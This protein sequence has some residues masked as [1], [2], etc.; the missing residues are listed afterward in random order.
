MTTT[1]SVAEMV[2]ALIRDVQTIESIYAATYSDPKYSPLA[3]SN[4][5][6]E[7]AALPARVRALEAVVDAAKAMKLHS[8]LDNDWFWDAQ[9]DDALDALEVTV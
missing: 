8:R 7:I 2:E 3:T 4:L 5:P 1:P 6:S 9:L